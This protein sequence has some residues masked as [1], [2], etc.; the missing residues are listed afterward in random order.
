MLK[1]ESLIEDPRFATNPGRVDNIAALT[2]AIADVFSKMDFASVRDLLEQAKIAN[3]RRNSVEDF[4]NHPQLSARE[5]FAT[6]GLPG[7]ASAWAM[8]PP[9]TLTN[10]PSRFDPVPAIGEHSELVREEFRR[11]SE[12]ERG[13]QDQR[14]DCRTTKETTS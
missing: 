2:A 11:R 9:A 13:G 3:S 6:V 12:S 7:G 8:R 1:D 5:R 10:T 14:T 4:V